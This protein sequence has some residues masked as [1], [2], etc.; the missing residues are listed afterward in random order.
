MSVKPVD[1]FIKD[2]LQLL[3]ANPS[4]TLVSFRYRGGSAEGSA[5]EVRFRTHNSHLGLHYKFKTRRQKDVSRVLSALGPRGVNVVAVGTERRKRKQASRDLVGMAT[6][7]VNADVK[8]HVP[9][10]AAAAAAAGSSRAK[11]SK[12]KG[13]KR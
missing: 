1:S 7:L 8:Q 12:K 5:A 3:C 6:L 13:K 10:P 9:E 2:S 11:K 4:Q